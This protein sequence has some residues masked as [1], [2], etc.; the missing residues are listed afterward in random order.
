VGYVPTDGTDWSDPDPESVGEALDDLA[1]A[2]G[3]SPHTIASHSDTT[4]TGAELETL[5]DGSN[6][7]A[8]HAHA[9]GSG[10]V[11]GPGSATNN[12]VVRFDETTGKLVQ[13]SGVIVDDSDNLSG[14]TS[15]T[16]S[17]HV[18]STTGHLIAS[19]GNVVVSGGATVDGVDV[20]V[21]ST[22]YTAHAADTTDPHGASM[23]VSTKV[24]TPEIDNAGNVTI[25][26]T[27]AGA[28]SKVI[29]E[30]SDGSYK[31]SLDVEATLCGGTKAHGDVGSSP[32]SLSWEDGG[33]QTLTLDGTNLTINFS[34]DPPCRTGGYAVVHCLVTQD[35][36]AYTVTWGSV[37]N[38]GQSEVPVQS[39]GSGDVDLYSF[40][41]IQ[42]TDTYYGVHV[43]NFG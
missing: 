20:S 28:N 35:T 16:A 6:A 22:N 32:L 10:D 19:T 41:Y 31:A 23:S 27:N 39:T 8:L 2:G 21:L 37:S 17:S 30:N 13:N 43:R 18:T 9:G 42:A 3:S 24:T 5:T 1:A 34:T 4:A 38:W 14:L 25:D 29:V 40:L 7:D 11:V 36:T 26:P 12:A 15:I 33:C